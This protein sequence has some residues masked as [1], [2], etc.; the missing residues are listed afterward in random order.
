MVGTVKETV[1][2][3]DSLSF[4][5]SQKDIGRVKHIDSGLTIHLACIEFNTHHNIL[6]VNNSDE[7][8][9]KKLKIRCGEK[10]QTNKKKK[11]VIPYNVECE[12][13][14]FNF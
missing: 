8:T 12:T 4:I 2:G 3:Q 1:P 6:R 10:K 11:A 14:P 7:S 5:I 9:S 13:S